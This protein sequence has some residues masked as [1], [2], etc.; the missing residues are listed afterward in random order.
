VGGSYSPTD[1]LYLFGELSYRPESRR[2]GGQFGLNWRLP[3]DF[4]IRAYGRLEQGTV[5]S[6]DFAH[7]FISNQMNLEITKAFSWGQRTPVAGAKPGQ[8][9]LGSGSIQ[10]HVFEDL[11]QNCRY[12]P[13][14][15]GFAG[16][17]VRLQDGSTATTD[18]KGYFR[19]PAVASGTTTVILE[20]KRIP[21]RYT[22]LGEQTSTLEVRRRAQAQ[23]DFPFILGADLRG[24]VV[25]LAGPGRAPQGLPNVLVLAQPGDYNTFTDAEGH[26]AFLGLPP[27]TYELSLHPESL[28]SHAVLASPATQTISL[29]AGAKSPPVFFRVN[30][31]RPVLILS[32]ISQPGR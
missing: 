26:F 5:G 19:F 11:N 31:E 30:T 22:F 1:R 8:E 18:D 25:A 16:V 7:A 4:A 2:F 29:T 10:G 13:G 6:G 24:Q 9:W 32:P 3:R 21:A 23:V 15:P 14:E 17:T 20:T 28:P 27:G 12:D